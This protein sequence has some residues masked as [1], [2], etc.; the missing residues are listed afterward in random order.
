MPLD[1]QLRQLRAAG[2][3]AAHGHEQAGRERNQLQHQ[4]PHH[5]FQRVARQPIAQRRDDHDVRDHRAQQGGQRRETQQ[6]RPGL[7][8]QLV[9][10]AAAHQASIA[11]RRQQQHQ[12]HGAQ[13][14]AA[15]PGQGRLAGAVPQAGRKIHGSVAPIHA[16]MIAG[17]T[18]PPAGAA[19]RQ[20]KSARRRFS[21][22]GQCVRHC[23]SSRPSSA[24]AISTKATN[25]QLAIEPPRKVQSM[26]VQSPEPR[27]IMG[28]ARLKG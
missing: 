28:M 17:R 25:D 3:G 11:R 7:H 12:H 15:P 2:N 10:H 21:K 4:H 22:T 24:S 13:V 9:G 6:H 14:D 19:P 8:I 1:A 27:K 26:A 18:W 16:A 23:R 5:H 20:K